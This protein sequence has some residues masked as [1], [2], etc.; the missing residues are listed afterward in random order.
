MGNELSD[1]TFGNHKI[2]L[3]KDDEIISNDELLAKEFE[4]FFSNA[5]SN[6][7]IPEIPV[8]IV[9]NIYDEVDTA[10]LKYK[11]HP[12]VVKILEKMPIITNEFEFEQVSEEYILKLLKSTVL[13][14]VRLPFPTIYLGKF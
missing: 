10:I 9:E 11:D 12:S 8:N 2:T 3:V 1:K 14:Q 13:N 4:T 5:V 6:L 7:D